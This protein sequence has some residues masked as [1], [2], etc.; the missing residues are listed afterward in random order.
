M[1]QV[2]PRQLESELLAQ[3]TLVQLVWVLRTTS[4]VNKHQESTWAMKSVVVGTTLVG[5]SYC[6]SGFGHN[7]VSLQHSIIAYW[8]LPTVCQVHLMVARAGNECP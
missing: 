8:A 5:I 2:D 7:V 1:N 3:E 4:T 6:F